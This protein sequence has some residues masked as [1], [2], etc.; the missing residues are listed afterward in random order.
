M[1]PVPTVIVPPGRI[2]SVASE[3]LV[4]SGTVPVPVAGEPEPVA[5]PAG[6][7]VE[8]ELDVE[9]DDVPLD[10]A[11][12][13]ELPDEDCNTCWTI[14]EIW[15]L[16]RLRA[17]WLAMLDRPLDRLVSAEAMTLISAASAEEAWLCAWAWVQ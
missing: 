15:L 5:V 12:D 9:L 2:P 8:P 13:E 3:V 1:A 6:E 11:G 14:A 4:V 7:A 16:T 17:V 10:P